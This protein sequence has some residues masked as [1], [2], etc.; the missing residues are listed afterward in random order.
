MKVIIFFLFSFIGIQI[1]NDKLDE[2]NG[3]DN[4]IFGTS[5]MA[6][7]NLVFEIEEDQTK[8]YSC[9]N[10]TTK[11]SGVEFEYIRITFYKDKLCA[12]A[13]QTRNATGTNLLKFLT[14]K[15]GKP[16]VSKIGYE[17]VGNKVQLTFESFNSGKDAMAS[18]SNKVIFDSKK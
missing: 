10:I 3:F 8:L 2:K 18:F 4:Y 15:Y 9:S 5:P 1:T 7:N 11:I 14:E 17:W 16:K 6:Y 13:I 12:I